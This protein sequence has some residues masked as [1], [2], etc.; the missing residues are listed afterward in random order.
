MMNIYTQE[1]QEAFIIVL[2]GDLDA[3]SCIELDNVL[4]E[5][6]AKP[7][8]AILVDCEKLAY[9][10]SA[11]LGV[12]MSHLSDIEEKKIVFALYAMSDKVQNVFEILGLQELIPSYTSQAEAL[13]A[14]P[15]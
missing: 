11:G 13:R 5:A 12:F 14:I 4:Y 1:K 6:I 9:I 7:L 10:S 3:S 8:K 2:E 15:L